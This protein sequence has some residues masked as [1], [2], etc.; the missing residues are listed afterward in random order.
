MKTWKLGTAAVLT[1]AVMAFSACAEGSSLS[2]WYSKKTGEESAQAA[3]EKTETPAVEEGYSVPQERLV[4]SERKIESPALGGAAVGRMMIPEDWTVKVTDLGLGTE[5][6]TCPN[7]VWVVASDPEGKREMAFL[8]R[9]EF[10]QRDVSMMGYETTTA[11]DSFDVDL[12]MHTLRYREADE[13]CGLMAEVLY[14]AE[15]LV[16]EKEFSDEESA[17]V[18]QAKA[19][20]EADVRKAVEET[21]IERYGTTLG[22]IDATAAQRTYSVG[23]DAVTVCASSS[24]YEMNS[25]TYGTSFRS[26]FWAMPAVFALK[27]PEG[28]HA[29]YEEAFDAFKATASVSHEYEELRRMNSERLAA[30]WIRARNEGTPYSPSETSFGDYEESTVDSGD[31]YSA[32]EGWDDYIRDETSY[33]TGDGSQVKISDDWEHVFEGDDGSIWVSDSPDGPIGSAELN[34]TQIGE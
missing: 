4:L 15:S 1:A 29:A 28:E 30:E 20:V 24:G 18:G 19:M 31:T 16:D 9:R 17:S 11:D 12:M 23:G 21:G 27:T 13:V 25:E 32:L 10:E 6:I 33:T 5:S 8:S 2:D 22:W 26:V 3:S 14:G 7:A 34:P